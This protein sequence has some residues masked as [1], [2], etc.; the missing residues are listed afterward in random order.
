MKLSI[1]MPVYNEKNTVAKV[2]ERVKGVELPGI[3]KELIV[4]D[5]CSTDGTRELLEEICAKQNIRLIKEQ[6][7]LGKGMAV[8]TGFK[9]AT[10][11]IFLIQDADMETNPEEYPL[12]LEPILKNRYKVVYGSR[13]KNGRGSAS[14]GN[15]WGNAIV[16]AFLNLF[17]FCRLS[18]VATVYK[19]FRSEVIKGLNFECRGFDFDIEI[20]AKI[21]KSGNDILEVPIAYDPRQAK[22][23]KKLHWFVGVRALML[24]LKYRF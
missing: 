2:L 9:H 17:F 24:I 18:D 11:E 3:D 23:G 22:D 15:Y 21:V 6:E 19:V 14:F 12:L 8:R 13:F 5:G 4:I 10:G 7:R 20:T 1:I 16:T